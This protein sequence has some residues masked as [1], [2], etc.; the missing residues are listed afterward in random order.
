MKKTERLELIREIVLEQEV[1]TQHDLL[2]KL[3]EHG[4]KLTQATISRDMNEVG[5]VKIP[6]QD[7]RYV[8]GLSK[9]NKQPI[10]PR[11]KPIKTSI[12]Q[13]SPVTGGIEHMIHIDVIPGNSRLVKKFLLKEWGSHIFS[14]IADDDS[15]LLIAKSPADADFVREAIITHIRDHH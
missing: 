9:E 8:Y 11:P 3:E 12:L 7:G 5:I 2:K 13:L 4:L 14:L 10:A 6:T 1:G 15:L